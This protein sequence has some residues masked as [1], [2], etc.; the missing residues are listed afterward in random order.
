MWHPHFDAYMGINAIVIT[1]TNNDSAI[2]IYM[3]HSLDNQCIR[4]D[5]KKFEAKALG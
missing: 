5:K 3:L 2:P 4:I 1:I